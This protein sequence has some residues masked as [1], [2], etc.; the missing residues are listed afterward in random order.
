MPRSK[1]SDKH[2]EFQCR[3]FKQGDYELFLFVCSGKELWKLVQVNRRVEDK[4]QGYQRAL[5]TSRV[6]RIASY[7]Q[8][9]NALPGTV[10]ISFDKGEFVNTDALL[11]VPRRPDAGWVLDGQH[12]LAGIHESTR[13]C[14]VP[15]VAFVGLEIAQQVEFFVTVN[16]EQ[17][18]VPSSLY[19]DLLKVL[20]PKKTE[21]EVL[22]ER[23][24]DL[25]ARLKQDETSPFFR[26]IV[27]VTSPKQ[28]E[29]STT[30]VVRKLYPALR[31]DG[32][33]L[34]T[35]ADGERVG[36]IN[37]YYRAIERV[38][39][40]EYRRRNSIF[41]RTLGF[42][43]LMNI[44]STVFQL[45]L[46]QRGGKFR[47]ADVVAVLEEIADYDFSN[48]RQMGTGTA[49]E[50]TAADDLRQALLLRSSRP[51]AMPGIQL[52]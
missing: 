35:F 46:T 5:S 11:R 7:V 29:L 30:N 42:G 4:D 12:R 10:L 37:N 28:G 44:F 27:T 19:Y 23:A 50:T 51:E 25:A 1:A 26:R 3:K 41:F 34:S 49:A 21:K 22:Q 17:K 52:E 8:D 16:K 31:G 14:D 18:G 13:D 38:F 43:A 33:F 24:A 9:G 39:P 36:I 48:W 47:V 40:E 15:V 6:K 32:G 45:T 2:V 20:P